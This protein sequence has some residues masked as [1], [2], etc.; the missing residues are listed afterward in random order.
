MSLVTGP[1]GSGKSTP[2]ACLVDKINESREEYIITIEDPIDYLL[3][4]KKSLVSQREVPNDAAPFSRALRAALRQARCG[5][6]GRNARSGYRAHRHHC[7]E[8]RP[9][10]CLLFR[11][12]WYKE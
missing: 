8:N 9:K 4:G 10:R 1:A 7:R 11:R 12:F 6:A 2:L 5:H 3:R